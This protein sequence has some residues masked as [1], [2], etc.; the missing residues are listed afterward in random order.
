MDFANFNVAQWIAQWT[1]RFKQSDS[2]VMGSNPTKDNCQIFC[3]FLAI[4]TPKYRR[5]RKEE[6][7]QLFKKE[8]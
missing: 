7:E 8:Y 2:K 4:A 1:S 6:K 3:V 5:S